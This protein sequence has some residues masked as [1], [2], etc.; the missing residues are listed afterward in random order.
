[1]SEIEVTKISALNLWTRE[2]IYRDANSS[3]LSD[4]CDFIG[5][6]NSNFLNLEL[7]KVNIT[8]MMRWFRIM[9][10]CLVDDL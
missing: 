7:A 1:M 2:I 8:Y 9:N 6:E 5:V 4:A 10:T 3:I